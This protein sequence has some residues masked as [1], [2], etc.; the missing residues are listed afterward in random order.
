YYEGPPFGGGQY[1]FQYRGDAA[2]LNEVLAKFGAVKAPE[3]LV[4]VHPGP[5]ANPFGQGGQGGQGGQKGGEQNRV[6]WTF[7]VWTPENFHRL[8]N[9]GTSLFMADRPDFRSELPPPR[10][11]VFVSDAGVKWDAV[12]LPAN[13]RLED[14]RAASHGYAAADGAVVVATV[15]DGTTSKPVAGA[16]LVLSAS[17][18]KGWEDKAKGVTGADGRVELKSVPAGGMYAVVRAAGYAP[19]VLGFHSVQGAAYKAATVRLTKAVEQAGR[20]VDTS[21]K[22][23]AGAEVRVDATVGIDGRGYP[24]ARVNE[25]P[26]VVTDAE[27]KF[28]LK[29]L[30]AGQAMLAAHAKGW[31]QTEFL[32]AHAITGKV[33]LTIVMAKTGGIKGKV[34]GA[35]A[36]D[37]ISVWP[38]GGSRPGT[39]GG[40]MNLKADG[41]FAF[42][43]VPPGKY[44][45][46]GNAGAEHSGKKD[47]VVAVEVKA[48]EVVEVE[49]KAKGL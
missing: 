45:V 6:D 13:V 37:T 39:W 5:G 44:F 38:E 27:G 31:H 40:G 36:G 35:K 11:D 43:A 17:V 1:V 8:Y 34:V 33:P 42:E 47:G 22:P 20:V 48:G 16:E 46:S 7:T 21:G 12:K 2:A 18:A 4:V 24:T 14:Q 10:L 28:I 15:Y 32:K 49:V 26:K 29:D 9:G 19:R 30:P 25:N 41:T 3:L 23:I